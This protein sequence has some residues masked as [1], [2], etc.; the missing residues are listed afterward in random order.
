LRPE[1]WKK[2]LISFGFLVLAVDESDERTDLKV[3]VQFLKQFWH[4]FLLFVTYVEFLS[5]SS[6]CNSKDCE[7]TVLQVNWRVPDGFYHLTSA[8]SN[9]STQCMKVI[10][11]VNMD[12]LGKKTKQTTR[13]YSPSIVVGFYHFG[14]TFKLQ[15][16]AQH[17]IFKP[18]WVGHP[19]EFSFG[20]TAQKS[21]DPQSS[22]CQRTFQPLA[23]EV[24]I[25]CKM[26]QQYINIPSRHIPAPVQPRHGRSRCS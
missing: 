15:L 24:K 2:E 1:S 12:T 26:H 11:E 6:L 25:R 4:L 17:V 10:M 14:G 19:P 23:T 20:A 8:D 9:Q 21:M 5:T 3:V 18:A 13:A 7:V 22:E 16:R